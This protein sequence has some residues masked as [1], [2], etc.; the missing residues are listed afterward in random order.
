DVPADARADAGSD[1]GI[2]AGAD[3]GTDTG[4]D[5]GTDAGSDAGAD[6]GADVGADAGRR[7]DD[8]GCY[9]PVVSV[10][11]GASNTCAALEDGRVLCLGVDVY[12]VL[13]S[14]AG[15]GGTAGITEVPGLPAIAEVTL[16][17]NFACGRTAAGEVWCWGD[18]HSGQV[19]SGAAF[20][21]GGAAVLPPTRVLLVDDARR[22]MSG[23]G[24]SCAIRADATLWCWGANGSSQLG[25]G[26]APATVATPTRVPGLTGVTS[27]SVGGHTCA[28]DGAGAVYCWGANTVGQV[29]GASTATP[30]TTPTR[31]A[32]VPAARSVAV[33]RGFTCAVT[34]ANE[35]WCWGENTSG[36]LARDADAGAGLVLAPGPVAGLAGVDFLS[37]GTDG[38]CARL[39]DGRAS[40]FGLQRDGE[41]GTGTMSGAVAPTTLAGLGGVVALTSAIFSDAP[42]LSNHRCALVGA[43]G[44]RGRVYC[45]GLNRYG[46]VGDGTLATALRPVPATLFP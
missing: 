14:G 12:G 25:L 34:Q 13:G 21:D 44:A 43:A 31:V 10:A 42:A 29:T 24:Y 30:L 26:T 38:M 23:S 33:G 6:A 36:R 20:G 41:L 4:T 9:S 18:N 15:D 11:A 35:A 27:A 46:Q 37:G 22:V 3:V 1:A 7:C 39:A 45:W 32:G 5:A 16:D 17:G 40:C 19:G 8:A 2:D 28:V